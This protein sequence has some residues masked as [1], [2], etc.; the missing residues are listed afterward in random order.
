MNITKKNI[1]K[2]LLG[3]FMI[4][5][6][7]S[8]E[9]DGYDEY[10]KQ[11]TPSIEMNGEWYIDISDASGVIAQH[12]HHVTYDTNDGDNTMYIND[13]KS[14]YTLKGTVNINTDNL[15]FEVSNADNILDPG[16]TF[17]ITEGKILKNAAHSK[18]GNITDSIYFKG[19]FSYDPGNIII[20]SG[21]K[22]TGFIDDNY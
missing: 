7:S 15:T 10:V 3:V 1:Y 20:F 21:H 11:E 16:T 17:I 9:N 2:L 5:I 14:G 19:E 12:S 18:S 6:I 4:S 22:R 13:N 8:C